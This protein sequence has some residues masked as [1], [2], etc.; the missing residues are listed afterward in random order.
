MDKEKKLI[1]FYED[2]AITLYHSSIRNVALFISVSLALLGYSRFYR[3]KNHTYNISFIIISLSFLFCSYLLC[4]NL[5]IDLEDIN[6]RLDKKI[7]LEKWLII[8]KIVLIIIISI[9]IFGL[10]TLKREILN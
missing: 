8:P 9:A 5:I 1:I 6:K 3:E 2:K 4:F 7:Y 10:Y